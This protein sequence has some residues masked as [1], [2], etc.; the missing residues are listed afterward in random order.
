MAH[1]GL[2]A[3][4]RMTLEMWNIFA[5]GDVLVDALELAHGSL[6]S[7]LPEGM[8]SIYQHRCGA[9]KFSIF[10]LFDKKISHV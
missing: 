6:A 7:Q 1:L 10:D 2:T 4:C 5:D 9:D 8:M 3:T